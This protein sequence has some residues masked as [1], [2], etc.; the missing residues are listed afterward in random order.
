MRD[1]LGWV[2]ESNWNGE[3]VYW[4]GGAHDDFRPE[5]DSAVRFAREIDATA[6][7]AGIH[8]QQVIPAKVT[9][10]MWCGDQPTAEQALE[11]A[12]KE[13][14]SLR[15]QLKLFIAETR[16]VDPYKREYRHVYSND[17]IAR[18]L[19]R[20]LHPVSMDSVQKEKA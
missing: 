17:G 8:H 1:E 11:S 7:L 4:C 14:A 20:I 19:E 6:V 15:E 10:H 5:N 2:I 9:E 16:E 18:R 12:E 13:L 3:V